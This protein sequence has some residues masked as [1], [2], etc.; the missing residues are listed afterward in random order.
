MDKEILIH[1]N[2]MQ[3]ASHGDISEPVEVIRPGEYY[4]KN[5]MHYIVFED[6][7]AD[8]G[9]V[10]KNF[11]KF[12]NEHLEIIKSGSVN[13][14]MLFEKDKK[15]LSQYRTP[16]GFIDIAV[17]TRSIELKEDNPDEL[18]LTVKYAMD[19]NN[20]FMAD[21]SVEVLARSKSEGINLS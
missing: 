2:G 5:G 20:S 16:F 18:A 9:E 14:T 11:L 12:R 19:V 4:F 6:A 21:C 17:S 8:T 15:T 3:F 1:I 13:V 10:T 7:D